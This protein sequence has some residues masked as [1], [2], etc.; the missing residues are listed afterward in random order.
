[1]NCT[2]ILLGGYYPHRISDD[3]ESLRKR[4]GKYAP[5]GADYMGMADDV[6]NT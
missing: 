5:G 6:F 4:L 3:E 1:M 2:W